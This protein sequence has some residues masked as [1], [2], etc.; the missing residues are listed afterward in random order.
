ME[1]M[2]KP[3]RRE[4]MGV[5]VA[6]RQ[7]HHQI[8]K[9]SIRLTPDA[10]AA[11]RFGMPGPSQTAASAK[12]MPLRRAAPAPSCGAMRN[13]THSHEH[14]RQEL[15]QPHTQNA[16]QAGQ[17]GGTPISWLGRLVQLASLPLPSSNRK[18]FAA[19]SLPRGHGATAQSFSRHWKRQKKPRCQLLACFL[20]CAK[21]SAGHSLSPYVCPPWPRQVP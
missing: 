9:P 12:P 17:D 3:L 14:C 1:P 21:R 6:V 20:R 4:R 10:V 13:T 19:P 15:L 18:S 7:M 8:S 11:V 2:P 16:S 5:V